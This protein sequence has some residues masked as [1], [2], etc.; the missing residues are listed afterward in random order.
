M[1]TR[2]L[3]SDLDRSRPLAIIAGRGCYPS[4]LAEAARA[5]G[6]PVRLVAFSGEAEPELISAFAP[7]E[8]REIEVGQLGALLS[9]LRELGAG[10]AVMA[11]QIAPRKLFSGMIPD[12]RLIALLARLPERNAETIFGAIAAEIESTGVRMIDARSFLDAH[13]ATEGRMTGWLAGS[14]DGEALAFGVRIAREMTRLDI[15]QAVVVAKG[16]VIA[17]EAFE[18]TDNMLRRCSATGGK[19]MLLVKA[20]KHG[21]DWRFDVPCFGERTLESMA[22][23]GVRQAALEVDGV[24]LLDKVRVLEKARQLGITLVGFR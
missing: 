19:E 17:V 14:V 6:M 7:S 13:L 16:T 3:P 5:A 23:G 11:G 24:L 1:A 10:N 20:A 18:G 2:F 22:E 12:L 21:Q 9:S 15:G 8:R 4:L